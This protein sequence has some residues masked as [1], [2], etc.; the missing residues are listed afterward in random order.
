[1]AAAELDAVRAARL[2]RDAERAAELAQSAATI[3][4]GL[5]GDRHRDAQIATVEA[6]TSIALSLAVIARDVT[7]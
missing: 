2:R 4:S 1:M 5:S 6:L 3:G 7:L